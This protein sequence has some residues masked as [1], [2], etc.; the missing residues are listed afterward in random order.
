MT[1]SKFTGVD[2]FDSHA[3]EYLYPV[4]LFQSPIALIFITLLSY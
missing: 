4:I 3:K 2:H 1:C